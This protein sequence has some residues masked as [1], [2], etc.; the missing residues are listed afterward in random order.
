[1]IREGENGLCNKGN[2]EGNRKYE[3]FGRQGSSIP[4]ILYYFSEVKAV[5]TIIYLNFFVLVVLWIFYKGLQPLETL[6]NLFL[7]VFKMI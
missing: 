4:V 3:E 2:A 6:V 1:M 5:G 7:A